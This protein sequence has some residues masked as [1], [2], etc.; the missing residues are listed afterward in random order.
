MMVFKCMI[1]K[2]SNNM[3]K[4]YI[5]IKGKG[6]YKGTINIVAGRALKN[7]KYISLAIGD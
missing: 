2:S 3:T 6:N 5:T 1:N 4:Y 7:E